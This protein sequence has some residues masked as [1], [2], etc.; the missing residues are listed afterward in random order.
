[1]NGKAVAGVEIVRVG[2]AGLGLLGPLAE[3]ADEYVESE[4]GSGGLDGLGT[5]AEESAGEGFRHTR[6]LA[7]QNGEG[8]NR[9]GGLDALGPLTEESAGEG[10][11][12]IRRLVDEYVNGRN[13]FDK[14]GE[15]LFCALRGGAVIGVGGVNRGI[16]YDGCEAVG[17]VRR[18]YVSASCRRLGVGRLVMDAVISHALGHFELLVLRTDNPD[19]DLFYRELGFERAE[20]DERVTHRMRLM[21]RKG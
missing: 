21:G 5:L 8:G 9:A 2:G 3:L 6:R 14:P 4:D 13:R 12:H 17:R 15:A 18:V 10:F 11:R 19:A 1:M 7:D 20:G 16:L